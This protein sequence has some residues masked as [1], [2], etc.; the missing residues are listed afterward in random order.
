M[1]PFRQEDYLRLT[2]VASRMQSELRLSSPPDVIEPEERAPRKRSI[3]SHILP[4]AGQSQSMSG[5]K[6]TYAC[7]CNAESVTDLTS[8]LWKNLT[9]PESK[10]RQS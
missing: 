6:H 1:T 9:S 2:L 8:A 10:F 7:T 3:L 5:Q 4:L